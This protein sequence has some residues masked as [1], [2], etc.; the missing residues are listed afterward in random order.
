MFETNFPEL[1]HTYDSY[2]KEIYRADAA[3]YAYMATEGGLYV[4][5]DM[6]CLR[7]PL[8]ML[9]PADG[10]ILACEGCRQFSNAFMMS[11]KAGKA[12]FR[13][14]LFQLPLAVHD[15]DMP[16]QA[17]GPVFFTKS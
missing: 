9:D 17:T 4:D 10:V 15:G 12:F 16:L 13:E 2:P 5:L 3:R 7:D 14:M 11:G 6:E 8:A 1:L